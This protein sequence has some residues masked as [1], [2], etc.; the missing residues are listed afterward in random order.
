MS[1]KSP[2]LCGGIS[3]VTL[4]HFLEK[5]RLWIDFQTNKSILLTYSVKVVDIGG[6]GKIKE[7][8]NL[9]PL[10]VIS[11]TDLKIASPF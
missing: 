11:T 2:V 9:T 7:K 1:W 5:F 3:L 4:L 10:N 8:R 6:K